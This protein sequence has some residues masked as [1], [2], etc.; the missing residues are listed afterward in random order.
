MKQIFT[1]KEAEQELTGG[2][3]STAKHGI[4]QK[5][6]VFIAYPDED[7]P[8]EA[9]EQIIKAMEELVEKEEK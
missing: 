3:L 4:R 9:A 1:E 8:K 7:D 6:K 2:T 5:K